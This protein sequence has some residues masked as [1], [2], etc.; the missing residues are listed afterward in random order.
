MWNFSRVVRISLSI[1][2][3]V[4]FLSIVIFGDGDYS[5]ESISRQLIIAAVFSFGLTA[6]NSFYYD[7]VNLRYSWEETP[8]KRLWIGAIG[9][10]VL[11]I[12]TFGLLRFL[13][14]YYFT[15]ESFMEFAAKETASSYVV[16]LIITLIAV[17]FSHAFSFS[18][19]I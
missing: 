2:V 10:F 15:G 13:V 4:A 12:C 9:S 14:N 1:T 19:N 11:T 17:L 18:P 3:F 7:G 8:K 6:V 16:A 5:L